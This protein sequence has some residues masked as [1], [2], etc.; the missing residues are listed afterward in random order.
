MKLKEIIKGLTDF[1]VIGSISGGLLISS[2]LIPCAFLG[3]LIWLFVDYFWYRHYKEIKD[4][5]SQVM[6]IIWFF[7]ALFGSIK[8]GLLV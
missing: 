1:K 2:G 8:W 7:I 5:N 4:T 3:H 6:F